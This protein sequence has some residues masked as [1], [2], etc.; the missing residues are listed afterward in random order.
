VRWSAADAL[1]SAFQHAPD[2]DV[3]WEDLHRLTGDKDRYVR[4]GVAYAFGSAFQHAPDKDVAWEDL[5]R[6][7]GDKDHYVRL[8]A[9]DA[10]GS[11]FQHVP[12]KDVAWEDLHRL[13]GDKNSDARQGAAYGLGSAFQHIPDKDVAWEDLHRLTGDKN[14]DVRR[15][16]AY[17]FGS[18]FQHVPDKD[19]A[20]EDLHRL[21]RDEDNNVRGSANH[22]LGKASIFK[23]TV[24]ESEGDFESE[25]NNAI[26]FFVRSSN[27][28]TYS[29]PSSFCLPFYRSFFM[30]AFEKT[31]SKGE[32]Q[33][34][35]A[36]AK[37]ASKGT[38][39]K[40][41][42]LEAVENL[43]SALTEA[44]KARDFGAMKSDLNAYR[45]YCDR[46][47]DLIGDA[48]EGAPGA[49]RILWRGLPIIDQRIKELLEE[50]KKKSESIC[51]TA[52]LP[53]SELGCKIGQHVVTALATDNPLILEREI[54]YILND[55]E[56]WS[57]SIRDENEKGYVQGIIF[58]AKNGDARGKVSSIRILI[59]RVLAFPED[60]GE[61]TSKYDIRNSIVQITK[62]KRNVQKMDLSVNSWRAETES[63]N[64]AVTHDAKV[65][66]E[67]Q[68]EE[69]RI[70]HRKKIT[71]E[72][73]AA[74]AVSVLVAILSPR[75]LENLTP[76]ASTLLASIALIILLVIIL[77]RNR[78]RSS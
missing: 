31:E 20:W 57:H 77:T 64:I 67:L 56:R 50:V 8:I 73:I 15:G 6:L 4:R 27:E 69:R 49:A 36:E 66:K 1:G 45:Q 53:E 40:E 42:L 58:D 35:L 25:L 12:D 32:V 74:I 70:D 65:T 19:V 7:T 22:S 33:R 59:G 76:T 24:A 18:A 26:D 61:E 46:A 75:Y 44:H 55:L 21:T 28:A 54:D 17:A 23:A 16:A 52:D 37:S 47:A 68:P 3:A 5:H 13:T 51:K 43:A 60:R 72:I 78:D 38:K 30:I 9:A 63:G 39:N 10:L 62:G 34:Y 11:A 48:S 71:I 14:S 29:N 2:K 41:T